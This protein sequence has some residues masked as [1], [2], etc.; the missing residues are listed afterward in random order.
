MSFPIIFNV[1]DRLCVVVGGGTVGRRKASAVLAGGGCVRL[2]CLD[3]QP[4]DSSDPHLEWL[5]EAY[6]VRHLEGASL[7][8]AAASSEV[9][10]RVV[11]DARQRNLWVNVADEPDEGDFIL[12]A[13]LRRGA[14]TVAVS[15]GGASP[16]L[17]QQVRDLLESQ[18][19]DAFGAWV[20][21]LSDLRPL[22]LE[23]IADAEQR[24]QL[25]ERWS[26][27]E[28]LEQLRREGVDAVH[29]RM[30]AELSALAEALK[31]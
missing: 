29:A 28:R 4:A 10:R 15:T 17:A 13:L 27:R 31:E 21:L 1:K 7:V 8:I 14:F 23:R 18:F 16:L 12:P 22:V 11:A 3:D 20:K 5:R 25:F 26:R 2:V 6:E 24:G 30:Q 9:N 19:D